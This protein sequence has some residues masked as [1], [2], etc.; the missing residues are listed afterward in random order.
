[1][2]LARSCARA[3]PATPR[4]CAQARER[5]KQ[6]AR[7][8]ARSVGVCME[9]WVTDTVCEERV[10]GE[11]RRVV[12]D[13]RR[14]LVRVTKRPNRKEAGLHDLAHQRSV[15]VRCFDFIYS[16][17]RR[18]LKA[19]PTTDTELKLIAAAAIIGFKSKPNQGYRTPAAT[20]TPSAL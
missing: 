17:T 13:V 8:L 5:C 6:G 2:P 7:P 9:T 3:A 18:S 20:G 4:E 15:G 19:F 1:M 12:Q 14:A 11:H 10:A 16:F